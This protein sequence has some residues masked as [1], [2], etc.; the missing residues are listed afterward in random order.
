MAQAAENQF[1]LRF[2][3]VTALVLSLVCLAAIVHHELKFQSYERDLQ[4]TCFTK[5]DFDKMCQGK[6]LVLDKTNT[7]NHRRQAQ[8][9]QGRS[10]TAL[11]I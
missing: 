4:P 5:R 10:H 1:S 6:P 9:G 2:V 8:D 3:S 11:N 7:E